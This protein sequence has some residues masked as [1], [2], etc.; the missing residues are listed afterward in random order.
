MT[1]VEKWIIEELPLLKM[2]GLAR[3][4]KELLNQLKSSSWHIY[5]LHKWYRKCVI[6]MR[7]KTIFSKSDSTKQQQKE[8]TTLLVWI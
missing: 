7:N 8:K 4:P 2:K 3:K 6:Y 1:S 5:R